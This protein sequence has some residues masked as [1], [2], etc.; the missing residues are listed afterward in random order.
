MQTPVVIV[1]YD[2]VWSALFDEKRRLILDAVGDSLITIE[3]IGSTAVPGLGAKPIIDMMGGLRSLDDAAYCVQSLTALSY[4]YWPEHE[5]LI[6]DR[7]YFDK[8]GYHL[9]L[10]EVGGNFWQRHLA[11]CNALRSH[12][13][14]AEEYYK[15][16]LAWTAK[17]TLAVRP[18][19]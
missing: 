6:P 11:F 18:S 9:H 10:A 1:P 4:R 16:K 19:S 12:L 2:S 8:P 13:S 3:Y 7:R 5:A 17:G 15:L 14:L